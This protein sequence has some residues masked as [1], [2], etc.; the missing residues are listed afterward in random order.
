MDKQTYTRGYMRLFLPEINGNGTRNMYTSEENKT[1]L[2][3]G[4][5]ARD[6]ILV[7]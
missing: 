1:I 3:D 7:V 5:S 4:E 6:T 2:L